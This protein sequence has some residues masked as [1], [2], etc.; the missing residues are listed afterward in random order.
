MKTTNYI[1]AEK[2]DLNEGFSSGTV[3]KAFLLMTKSYLFFIPFHSIGQSGMTMQ[4]TTYNNAADLIIALKNK[5]ANED[6]SEVE[7]DLIKTLPENRVY[8][9]KKLEKLSVQVGFW[10]FGGMRIKKSG[11]SLQVVNVQP[12][13]IRA[14]I[15]DFYGL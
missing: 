14:E 11:G 10:I 9:V 8:E 15:K 5:L 13:T 3:T 6:I 2:T 7:A 12:K 4:N 1:I